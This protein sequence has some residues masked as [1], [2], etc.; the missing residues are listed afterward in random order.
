MTLEVIITIAGLLIG[1][2][3]SFLLTNKVLKNKEK[4]AEN[5]AKSIVSDAEKIKSDA[6][7]FKK[8]RLA[9]MNQEI[10]KKKTE[11]DSELQSK[12]AKVQNIEK[13]I[14]QREDQIIQKENAIN[15]KLE[16]ISKTEKQIEDKKEQI[17]A[18][19]KGQSQ[20]LEKIASMTREEAKKMLI[21]NV[22]HE[23][24]AD[25]AKLLNKALEEVRNKANQEAQSV[26]LSAIQRSATDICVENTVTVVN[27]ESD[28]MK[29]RIIGREGRNIRTFESAT[30]V[31][32]IVDDTPESVVVSGYDPFRREIAKRALLKLT[33]DGR[34]H[35]ARIEEVVAKA[36]KEL[37]EELVKIGADATLQ[38]GIHNMNTELE[39][40][41]GR[42]RYRSSFGQNLLSHSIEVAYISGIIASEIGLD[43]N[44][45]KRAALLHDI[46]KCVDREIEGP[47]AKLGADIAKKYKE[48]QIIINAIEAH[49][50]DVE[51]ESPYA[52]IVQIA[53]GISGARPGARKESIENYMKRL[54]KLEEISTSFEGVSKCFVIQAGREIRV[55]VEPEK[56]DDIQSA[57]ISNEIAKKIETEM[58]YPG[59]IKVTVIREK[60]NVSIAK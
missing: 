21:E 52:T 44:I 15:Q 46:G 55:I 35:P 43:S 39:R 36:Q 51:H 5:R 23:I 2:V 60:R 38:L 7:K 22:K 27:L 3:V 31:D 33:N 59:Q 18:M 14:K 58:E 10:S 29:G 30:G 17:S 45:A 37:E 56:V 57:F 49:H 19:M 8:D 4:E 11:Y 48:N 1:F 9:E 41:V 47:H 6:E 26:I 12:K 32:L 34:I 40:A 20:K 28:E 53:D 25:T 16:K 50:D 54:E 42:M 13:Q 24:K